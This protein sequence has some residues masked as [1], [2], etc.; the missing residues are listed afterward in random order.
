MQGTHTVKAGP[1]PCQL[2]AL[3]SALQTTNSLSTLYAHHVFIDFI[4]FMHSACDPSTRQ[5]DVTLLQTWALCVSWWQ[6]R[7]TTCQ[8]SVSSTCPIVAVRPSLELCCVLMLLPAAHLQR[9]ADAFISQQKLKSSS[10]CPTRRECDGN[11]EE[12]GAA[13]TSLAQLNVPAIHLPS[14]SLSGLCL[15]THESGQLGTRASA[16]IAN[17]KVAHQAGGTRLSV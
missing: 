6:T 7:C 17:R 9:V 1:Q 13:G 8:A 11:H 4:Q 15:Q 3:N 2:R 10:T 14:G 5:Q 16:S 12:F